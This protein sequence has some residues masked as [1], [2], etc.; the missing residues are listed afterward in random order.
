M[1]C[2]PASLGTPVD[3]YN[4]DNHIVIGELFFKIWC[5][6]SRAT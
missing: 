6:R 3:A 5:W 2:K 1:G 4:D